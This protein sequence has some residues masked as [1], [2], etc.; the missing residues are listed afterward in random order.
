MK[1]NFMSQWKKRETVFDEYGLRLVLPGN[2][3]LRS[4]DGGERWIY[5][6]ADRK[7]QIT[8]ATLDLL[9]ERDRRLMKHRATTRHRRAVELGLGREPE[10]A[11]SEE[12]E[13]ECAGVESVRYEGE[14]NGGSHLFFAILL[15]PKASVGWSVFY[16]AFKLELK[17]AELRMREVIDSMALR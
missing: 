17:E 4:G 9:G 12:E 11:L 16:E 8:I 13:G 14:A 2:W 5:R 15:F 10:F 3:Q 7:E 6:S 1:F